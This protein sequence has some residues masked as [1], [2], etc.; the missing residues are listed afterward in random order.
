MRRVRIA[1]RAV[2]LEPRHDVAM[3]SFGVCI[4][5]GCCDRDGEIVIQAESGD[6]GALNILESVDC[7]GVW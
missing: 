4:V 5:Q 6:E 2:L 7:K 3:G 1:C